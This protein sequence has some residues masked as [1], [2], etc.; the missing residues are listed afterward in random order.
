MICPSGQFVARRIQNRHCERSDSN[1]QR[2]PRGEMDCFVAIAPRNDVGAQTRCFTDDDARQAEDASPARRRQRLH[3]LLE[4]RQRLATRGMGLSAPDSAH[5]TA[6]GCASP[7]KRNTQ[8]TAISAWPMRSPNQYGVATAARSF[9][10]TSSTPPICASQRSTQ[11]FDLLLPQHALINQ[12][13]RLVAEPGR[14]RDRSATAAA[15]PRRAARSSPC[16]AR[17][18]HPDNPGSP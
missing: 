13:D 17:P 3:D 4:R 11:I 9:S 18:V 1:P 12:A 6:A 7:V 15:A 2:S 10:S 16:P 5:R 8:A 14:Q